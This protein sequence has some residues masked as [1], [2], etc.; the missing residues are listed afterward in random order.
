MFC[1]FAGVAKKVIGMILNKGST[2]KR[3][4]HIP[5]QDRCPQTCSWMVG[6]IEFVPLC[7]GSWMKCVSLGWQATHSPLNIRTCACCFRLTTM[8]GSVAVCS[9]LFRKREIQARREGKDFDPL[10][11]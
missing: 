11:I 3:E 1:A 7:L 6:T 2:S 10:G 8:W 4:Q 9:S 5:D